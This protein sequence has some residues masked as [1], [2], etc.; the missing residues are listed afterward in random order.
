MRQFYGSAVLFAAALALAG[1]ALAQNAGRGSVIFSVEC[2]AC[3]STV[4]GQNGIG[5]SLAGIYGS[6]AG[7]VPGFKF[8]AALKQSNIIWTTAA[9]ETFLANPNSAV[10]G[11]K[12]PDPIG[13]LHLGMPDPINRGDVIAYLR[14][15]RQ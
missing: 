10:S 9:L 6:R 13:E 7:T 15:L 12:M 5:P 1:P 14:T 4:A 11:T 8:S 2:A 3:H